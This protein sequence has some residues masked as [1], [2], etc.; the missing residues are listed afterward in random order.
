MR[1]GSR[2]ILALVLILLAT[3]LS[4]SVLLRPTPLV[5][6]PLG[7][8]SESDVQ[9]D[10]WLEQGGAAPCV[11]AARYTPLRE[12]FHVYSIDLP[13]D[14]VNGVG[15]P[16]R[17]DIVSGLAADGDLTADA[18]PSDFKT[19][20]TDE[21]LPV[22]PEGPV[23]LRLAVKVTGDGNAQVTVSYMACSAFLCLPPTTKMLDINLSMCQLA[24]P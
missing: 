21:I 13:P 24:V 8:F 3:I 6:T 1:F 19:E 16:T 14:G 7:D 18:T 15:R 23:T 22:Y 11:L 4:L 2:L 5:L 9:V 17:L 20:G 12:H 10:L